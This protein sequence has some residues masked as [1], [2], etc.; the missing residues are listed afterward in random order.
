MGTDRRGLWSF[1][2]SIFWSTYIYI[3]SL[4]ANIKQSKSPVD[5]VQLLQP[6][7]NHLQEHARTTGLKVFIRVT[8]RRHAFRK[9]AS[10]VCFVD[11]VVCFPFVDPHPNLLFTSPFGCWRSYLTEITDRYR[12]TFFFKKKNK[13]IF[14]NIYNIYIYIKPA[15]A[16]LRSAWKI[17]CRWL[18]IGGLNETQFPCSSSGRWAFPC[19]GACTRRAN[20]NTFTDSALRP[21][22]FLRL[23]HGSQIGGGAVLENDF[24]GCARIR[25]SAFGSDCSSAVGSS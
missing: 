7:R 16:S 24:S 15:C 14:I 8:V 4:K 17:S 6:T 9:I 13:E 3:Y 10:V 12:V 20:T 23:H 11:A 1:W 22:L 21:S 18:S 25:S 19:W 5:A 2:S